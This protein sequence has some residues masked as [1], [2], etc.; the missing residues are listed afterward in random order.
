VQIAAYANV[1]GAGEAAHDIGAIVSAVAGHWGMVE[2][3]L[4][5]GCHKGRGDSLS[6]ARGRDASTVGEGS[7]CSPSPFARHDN[8]FCFT[9]LFA[10][11]QADS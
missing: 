1:E 4:R 2:D 8:D 7:L 6:G 9:N 11:E 5:G 3:F 10:A